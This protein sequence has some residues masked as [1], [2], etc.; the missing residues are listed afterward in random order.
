[1]IDTD[2]Y[3]VIY[4]LK[5]AQV[6]IVS[7]KDIQYQAKKEARVETNLKNIVPQKYYNFLM[8]PQRKT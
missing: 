3:Y 1:M 6:F 5:R 7:I 2:T 4:Y 8:F